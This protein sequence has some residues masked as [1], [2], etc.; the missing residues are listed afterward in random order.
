MEKIK[1]IT[2]ES[3]LYLYIILCPILDCLSFI[4]RN[5]YKTSISPSTII[6]PVC[7]LLVSLYVFIKDKKQRK[8]FIFAGLAY[9]IYA[10]IHL[11][12]FTTIQNRSS[13]GGIIH[14][15]QYLVNYTFM[16]LNLYMYLYILVKNKN[17]HKLYKCILISISIYIIS[18]YL[19]IITGTSSY[20]YSLEEIG[21]K[22]WFESGNSLSA[23]F[24]LSL[25]ILLNIFKKNKLSN[26]IKKVTFVIILLIGIFLISL[27]GTRVG[28][29]GFILAIGMFGIAHIIYNIINKIAIR[30]ILIISGIVTAVTMIVF[31][32]VFTT[33]GSKTIDRRKKVEEM[34]SK[35]VDETTNEKIH[36]TGDMYKIKKQIE[37][38][39]IEQDYMSKEEQQAVLSLNEIAKK[40]NL[41]TEDMRTLQLIYNIE[42]ANNQSNLIYRLFGNGYV[43]QYREMILE[44]EPLAIIL[45]FGILGFV[46]YLIPFISVYGYS[47]YKGI[48][49]F[50]K[51]DTEYIMLVF[52]G[53][54]AFV[55]SVLSG[56]IFFNASTTMIIILINVLLVNK[57]KEMKK[58]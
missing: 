6:R 54:L 44:M 13:Y 53:G 22:G 55:L 57:T 7:V 8:I 15:L 50:R 43:C 25:F 37:V 20:T 35:L 33:Y 38:G 11:Y 5:L 26:K 18:I 58:S 51:I 42:L 24:T 17:T 2:M 27:I 4:F 47:V 16:I 34:A 9:G 36:I 41:S 10:I 32:I 49:C 1:K 31:T 39:N 40:Y 52:G 45:N 29:L 46:L 48:I 23:I 56:Y 21:Y 12:I 19:A 30:K 28:L 3:F 14:E